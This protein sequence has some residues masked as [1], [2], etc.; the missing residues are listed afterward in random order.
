MDLVFMLWHS[1]EVDGDTEQKLIGVYKTHED[2]EAAIG[3]VQDMPGFKDTP[4]G[5]EIFE[6]VLGRDGWTE[7]YI[8]QAPAMEV[9]E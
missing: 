7:G 5:F 9:V 8:S 3:R 6:Y 1:Y 4:D 2:G